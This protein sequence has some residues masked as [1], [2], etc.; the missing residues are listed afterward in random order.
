MY[1][2]Y[3]NPF[4]PA[5]FSTSLFFFLIPLIVLEIALKGYALWR[6][7]R[8]GQSAWFCF[9]F[10]LST[11]GILP[12]IYLAFFQKPTVTVRETVASVKVA[13]PVKKSSKK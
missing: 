2:S 8:N 6:A 7:A 12:I 11:M 10:I 9:L 4:W 3:R 5:L 13:K 1:N